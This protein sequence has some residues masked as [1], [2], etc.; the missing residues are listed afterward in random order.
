MIM[1]TSII[2]NLLFLI[3]LQVQHDWTGHIQGYYNPPIHSQLQRRL[4]QNAAKMHINNN[5]MFALQQEIENRRPRD[6]RGC[7][8][9]KPI[10]WR[11]F[12]CRHKYHNLLACFLN[13]HGFRKRPLFSQVDVFRLF[14]RKNL[15]CLI[16]FARLESYIRLICGKGLPHELVMFILLFMSFFPFS[17][18]SFSSP[19][20]SACVH[21]RSIPA[22]FP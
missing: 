17:S 1:Y 13:N 14:V 20:A 18:F 12:L 22:V 3:L 15:W 5:S 9:L 10:K 4:K 11:I 8:D 7:F 6:V 19:L 16:I 2:F 21:W